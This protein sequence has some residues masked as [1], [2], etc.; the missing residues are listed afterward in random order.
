MQEGVYEEFTKAVTK[1]V[2]SFKLGDGLAEGTTLGPLINMK[3]VDHVST[4]ATR[5]HSVNK[6]QCL[7][8]P[9]DFAQKISCGSLT[10]TRL[11]RQVEAHVEDAKSKGAKVLTGGRRPQLEGALSKGYF[12]EP[13]V[14]GDAS[15]DMRIYKEETFGPAIPCF[16]FKHDADA[17]KLA[18]DTEYGL[19][20]Y[21]Y[22]K[23][24]SFT[25][26][27]SNGFSVSDSSFAA[28]NAVQ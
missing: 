27:T 9:P 23:A 28:G 16:R 5:L 19:A 24:R 4:C 3:A 25:Q 21:F 17:I 8:V 22:T 10:E 7:D 11:W 20:A 14:L 13:T 15:T 26:A 6:D 1:K 18:N 2:A 12:F